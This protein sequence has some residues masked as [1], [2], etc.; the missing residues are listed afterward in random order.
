M[1]WLCVSICQ[2]GQLLR[3]QLSFTALLLLLLWV[4]SSAPKCQEY[5]WLPEVHYPGC[6]KHIH[7]TCRRDINSEIIKKHLHL[8][9]RKKAEFDRNFSLL[10][11][12]NFACKSRWV[13]LMTEQTVMNQNTWSYSLGA[14]AAYSVLQ[15]EQLNVCFTFG[16]DDSTF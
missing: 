4:K 9:C 13:W 14:I 6:L 11:Q 15:N 10:S 3:V 16:I 8:L 2:M 12:I 5:M 1:S 7:S